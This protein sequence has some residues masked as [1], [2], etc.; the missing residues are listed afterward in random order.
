MNLLLFVIV[1]GLSL[2]LE[3]ALNAVCFAL[4]YLTGRSDAK[5]VSMQT[6]TGIVGCAM[7]F[8]SFVVALFLQIVSVAAQWM[9]TGA[10]TLCLSCLLYVVFEYASDIMFEAGSAYNGGLSASLQILV[11]W[12][13][14]LAAMVFEGVCP[15][16]NVV[17][18][19]AKKMPAQVKSRCDLL[20]RFFLMHTS[21]P[22]YWSRR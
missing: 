1:L 8:W 21:P 19:V 7:N 16:W 13:A 22:R 9:L 10:L 4:L 17:F 11:V 14:K 15:V 12:P 18:W 6:T 3:R 5:P 2:L 20:L